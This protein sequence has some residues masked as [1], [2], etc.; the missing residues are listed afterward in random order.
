MTWRCWLL[1]AAGLAP[2]QNPS[3]D[4]APGRRLFEAQCALCHGQNGG[5]G[6]GPTLLKPTLAKAPD[7]AALE[8]VIENGIAPEMPG[9]W[10]LSPNEVKQVAAYVRALGRIAPELVPGSPG[11][12][13]EI[14]Q[15]NACANCH[16]V[17]GAGSGYGPE[18]TNIGARRSAAHL[19][20]S[21]VQPAAT[22]PE[23]FLMLQATPLTG[24]AITGIRLAEDP[25][26]IQL[27]DASGR[28]HTFRK[29]A[30]KRLDKLPKRSPMPA[31]GHLAENDLQD[32]IAYLAS[33]K[34]AK[35]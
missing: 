29:A 3:L 31:Y 21:M 2:A 5:G 1:L 4:V 26:S 28:F 13:G 12:G 16:I 32:L 9:A 10:Q 34:G 18:L 25:F 23:G 19:R 30:L 17:T 7:A 33:L 22:L 11:R 6:R 15:R 20:E 8:K 24:A 35:P 27:Q 14:Y